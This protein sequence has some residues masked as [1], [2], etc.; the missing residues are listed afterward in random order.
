MAAKPTVTQDSPPRKFSGAIDF[1]KEAIADIPE[2]IVPRLGVVTLFGFGIQVKV[3]RGHLILEDGIGA[4]RRQAR[5]S[6]VGH[7]LR[8]LVVI[9]A[10]GFVSLAALRWLSDQN[11]AFVMLERNGTVLA[12]TGPVAAS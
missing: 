12:V 4:D 3:E 1:A 7:D 11:G 6:R 9:G 2:P 5:F 8:R 10:D